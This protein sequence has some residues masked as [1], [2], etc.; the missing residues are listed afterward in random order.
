[1]IITYAGSGL[2]PLPVFYYIDMTREE[3]KAAVESGEL[4]KN[5]TKLYK[6]LGDLG[7]PFTK[8]NCKKCHRDY[9]NMIKEELGMIRSAADESD[10]NGKSDTTGG[11][12][13][14]LLDRPQTWNRKVIGPDTD[15]DTIRAFVGKFPNGYYRYEE[16]TIDNAEG[17][18]E[19][20]EAEHIETEH[21]EQE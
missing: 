20:P 6:A 15:E 9:L 7:L 21:D 14:Y 19:T 4:A 1:L 10:F 12:W 2:S 5:V 17:A 11:K 13:V 3:I 18:V 8:T 16:Q